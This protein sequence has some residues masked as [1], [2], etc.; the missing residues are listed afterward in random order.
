VSPEISD[1]TTS[2]F[3]KRKRTRVI[4]GFK[5]AAEAAADARGSFT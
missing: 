1:Q 2:D 5:G 4:A 3:R